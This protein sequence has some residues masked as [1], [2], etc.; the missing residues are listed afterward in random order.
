MESLIQW[1]ESDGNG[2]AVLVALGVGVLFACGMACMTSPSRD[3]DD[4]FHHPTL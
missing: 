2:L 4:F 1:F 3:K